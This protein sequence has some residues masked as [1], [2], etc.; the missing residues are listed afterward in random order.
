MIVPV[1]VGINV[2]FC[3]PLAGQRKKHAA[4]WL[5]VGWTGLRPKGADCEVAH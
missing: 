5:N 3:L 4:R 1:T 2:K